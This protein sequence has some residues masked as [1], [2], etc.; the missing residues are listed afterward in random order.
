LAR[1]LTCGTCLTG[2]PTECKHTHI[3]PHYFLYAYEH[4]PTRRLSCTSRV[5]RGPSSMHHFLCHVLVPM[6]IAATETKWCLE[7]RATVKPTGC[8][9][10]LQ[11]LVHPCRNAACHDVAEATVP[12]ARLAGSQVVLFAFFSRVQSYHAV[13]VAN[14]HS[15]W[16]LTCGW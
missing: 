15:S 5:L 13:T 2:F 11:V 8:C 6:L 10:M 3:S 14:P 1:N 9:K 16:T 12:V 4:A 7:K